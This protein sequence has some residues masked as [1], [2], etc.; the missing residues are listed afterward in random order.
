MKNIIELRLQSHWLVDKPFATP[1]EVVRHYGCI[2]SQ[3]LYQATR[4]VASR[5]DNASYDNIKQA[6][7]DWS[8]I[9]TWPM[10]GTLHYIAPEYVHWLLDICASK[11]LA[12]FIKRREFL[13]ISPKHAEQA[14]SIIDSSLRGWKSLTRS[15]I[16][17]VLLEWWIPMQ[18]QRVYHL[19]CYAA[20][21]KLICFGPPTDTEETFVLLDEWVSKKNTTT[22]ENYTELARMYIRS[23]GPCTVDDLARWS[24]LWKWESKK[25]IELVQHEFEKLEYNGKQYFYQN[26]EKTKSDFGLRLLWWF[27]EYFLAYKDR[28]IVADIEHHGKLFTT[29]GIFFPLIMLDGKIIW[30]RKRKI[31][32]NMIDINI[33]IIDKK[34]KFDN[35]KLKEQ[36]KKYANFLWITDVNLIFE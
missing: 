10:R 2:Q 22:Q 14:L 23:H 11:T 26:Y 9:R 3:D 27:D 6:C 34:A 20:T 16:G 15:Q 30:T 21:S 7:R 35:Q 18:T 19:T 4:V 25:A 29:N 8:I 28:S 1:A 31:K 5:T 17:Q 36:A 13:W 24:G 12:S 33:S 32:K